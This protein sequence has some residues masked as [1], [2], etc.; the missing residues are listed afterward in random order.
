MRSTPITFVMPKG[1]LFESNSP[2][3]SI[4]P[5]EASCATKITPIAQVGPKEEMPFIT[6]NIIITPRIPPDKY[7]LFADLISFILPFPIIKQIIK[8]IKKAEP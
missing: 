6:V 2:K 1:V 4:I 7:S 5:A 8:V 3:A